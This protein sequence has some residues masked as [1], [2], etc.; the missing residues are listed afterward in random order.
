[1]LSRIRA[2]W[3]PDPP[4]PASRLPVRFLWSGGAMSALLLACLLFLADA[5]QLFFFVLAL[6]ALVVLVGFLTAREPLEPDT[7]EHDLYREARWYEGRYLLPAEDFDYN[8]GRLLERA[9][10]AIDLI[11]R[12]RVNAMGMLD[13]VR[14]AV[15]L[16]SQEW[17]IAQLLTKLSALRNEHHEF[18]HGGSTPEV[19]AAMAPL[20]RALAAS[21]A[22]VLA[23]VEALERYAGHVS[24]AE[25]ALRAHEQIEVLRSRLPRYEE[26]LAESGADAFAVPEIGRLTE[27]ADHLEQ[28]LR[29]S[30]R[31]AHEAFRHLD[32]AA[33]GGAAGPST[34]PSEPSSPPNSGGPRGPREDPS[35]P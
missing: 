13:D 11:L 16:P 7:T 19:A 3:S 31:S 10:R 4:E 1:M 29:D 34:A 9:Q 20:E 2:G 18:V 30:V 33:A 24:D 8:A 32:G 17:E 21:E 12:S 28:A 14:N 6:L 15:T 25:Q 35:T 27:D 22:A 23:R 5:G 26:L